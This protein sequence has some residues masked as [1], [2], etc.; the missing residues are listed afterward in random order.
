MVIVLAIVVDAAVGIGIA[1]VME[2]ELMKELVNIV[3]IFRGREKL[4][5]KKN[6]PVVDVVE[7]L[8]VKKPSLNCCVAVAV[9][10]PNVVVAV[11]V[12]VIVEMRQGRTQRNR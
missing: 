12:V 7:I 11:V 1:V 10:I 3:V 9:V 8:L 2:C 4:H 5:N 6:P